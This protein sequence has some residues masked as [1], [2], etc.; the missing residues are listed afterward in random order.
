MTDKVDKSSLDLRNG[1]SLFFILIV[2]FCILLVISIY[3]LTHYLFFN[4]EDAECIFY[5]DDR[6]IVWDAIE[7]GDA[8]LCDKVCGNYS[9]EDNR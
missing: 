4:F 2:V 3:T 8:S 7:R 9:Q 6:F 5:D 1:I